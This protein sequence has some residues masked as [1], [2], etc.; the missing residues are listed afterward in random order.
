MFK[1]IKAYAEAVTVGTQPGA[2]G[3]AGEPQ[4]SLYRRTGIAFGQRITS[5]NRSSVNNVRRTTNR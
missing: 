3:R 1:M 2:R 5:V 4:G